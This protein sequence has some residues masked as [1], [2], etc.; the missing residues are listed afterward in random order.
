MRKETDLEIDVE[1]LKE[2]NFVLGCEGIDLRIEK[3]RDLNWIYRG[4]FVMVRNRILYRKM[5]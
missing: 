3:L 5:G 1:L 2:N 4:F